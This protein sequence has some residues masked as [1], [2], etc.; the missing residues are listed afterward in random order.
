M[1][2][3][4]L[5]LPQPTCYQPE[6]EAYAEDDRTEKWKGPG[7]LMM[8]LNSYVSQSPNPSTAGL[9]ILR[10]KHPY[11]LITNLMVA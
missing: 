9:S 7:A 1:S 5:L 8:L 10:D 6:N 4:N 11:C 3:V 2:D